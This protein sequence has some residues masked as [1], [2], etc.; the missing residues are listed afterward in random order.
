MRR[1]KSEKRLAGVTQPAQYV[2]DNVK[3]NILIKPIAEIDYYGALI[4]SSGIHRLFLPM[5]FQFIRDDGKVKV[6][7]YFVNI[8]GY[9][10]LKE[11]LRNS[12]LEAWDI[13]DMMVQ[14]IEGINESMYK[15]VFPYEYRL[16]LDYIYYSK[17]QKKF[18]LMFIP[19]TENLDDMN[20]LNKMVLERLNA[21]LD[22]FGPFIGIVTDTEIKSL[23]SLICKSGN[24]EDFTAKI[25]AHKRNIWRSKQ[26][27][28]SRTIAL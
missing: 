22:E 3:N 16:S 19:S 1:Y 15:Y 9:V 20:S 21:L 28:I 24:A 27:K 26:G 23:K 8:E 7:E 11:Y 2:E 13:A 17:S 14:L 18:K 12:S 4:L 5:K 25:N 10:N 6:N